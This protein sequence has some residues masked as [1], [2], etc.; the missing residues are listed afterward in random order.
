MIL[1]ESATQIYDKIFK[2]ILSLS[3]VAVINFINALFD[4]NFP[5]NSK[6]YQH[7]EESVNGNLRKTFADSIL[8]INDSETFHMEA[9]ITPDDHDMVLRR[10]N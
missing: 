5:L 9:E 1:P 4:K 10:S 2:R 3:N 8:S 7:S 6:V